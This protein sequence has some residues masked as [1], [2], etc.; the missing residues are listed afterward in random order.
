[1]QKINH[2]ADGGGRKR[3]FEV[4]ME[5]EYA[6]FGVTDGVMS[7]R[8]E[9]RQCGIL[10]RGWP[11]WCMAAQARGWSISL[12]V[13]KDCTWEKEIQ[14]WFP[15]AEIV[16]VDK[17]E[18]W[19]ISGAEIDVWYSDVDPPR[20]LNIWVS[21]ASYIISSR[22]ARNLASGWVENTVK[23]SHA[24]CGGV[25]TG[26]WPFFLYRRLSSESFAKPT[27]VAGRDLSSVLNT[28]LEGLPCAKP[29]VTSDLRREAILI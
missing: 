7:T 14:G 1:M 21:R 27:L 6:K 26:V 19:K 24:E 13:V 2:R 25:T 15:G 20:K 16:D 9:Q 12:I 28:K 18:P 4:L 29:A 22:R 17:C 10:C 8:G 11:G 3:A 23:L 5:A